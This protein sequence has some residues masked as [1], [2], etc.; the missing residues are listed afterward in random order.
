MYRPIHAPEPNRPELGQQR[1]PT[2]QRRD[3]GVIE[4]GRIV[5]IGPRT[6]EA[7]EPPALGLAIAEGRIEVVA[8]LSFEDC[9]AGVEPVQAVDRPEVPQSTGGRRH[10]RPSS[11]RIWAMERDP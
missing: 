9:G 10:I 8:T 7:A 4:V 2:V 11:R 3:Q 6:T 1:R 5:H